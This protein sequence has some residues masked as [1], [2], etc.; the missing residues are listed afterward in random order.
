MPKI[1]SVV[2][3]Y[4][5]H[6]EAEAA[7]LAFQSSG[8]D[9]KKLSIA[10]KDYHSEDHVIGFYNAGDRMKFWGKRGA[11]WGGLWGLLLGSALFAIPG[12][13]QVMVLGPLVGW[14]V[15]A[16]GEAVVVGGLSALGAGLYSI[17]IPR[18]SVVRYETAIKA[19]HFVVVAH[20]NSDEVAAAKRILDRTNPVS[21]EEHGESGPA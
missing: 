16:M 9:M 8:F 3:I 13:G 10:G 18:D 1:A 7:V 17:G 20:G 4:N 15:G 19:D 2:A 21:I 12:F 5:T 14:I 6:P 11:F